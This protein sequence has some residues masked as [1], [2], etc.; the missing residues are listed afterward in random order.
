MSD[1]RELLERERRR[2]DMP[3]DGFDRLLL[4]RARQ[5]R[6]RRREAGIV[7]LVVALVGVGGGL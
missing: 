5:Q 4:R 6:R 1:I 2:F 3:D 7:A